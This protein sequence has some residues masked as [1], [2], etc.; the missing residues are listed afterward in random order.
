MSQQSNT[1]KAL[2]S[3]SDTQELG[4]DLAKSVFNDEDVQEELYL[5]Y[6]SELVAWDI[7]ALQ[8]HKVWR[9]VKSYLQIMEIINDDGNRIENFGQALARSIYG[10]SSLR[11][12]PV[13]TVHNLTGKRP[14]GT[15]S[16]GLDSDE[17]DK[18]F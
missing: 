16:Y 7:T 3:K 12:T 14:L 11:Y 9:R 5:W 15:I 17:E 2:M 1:L 13:Y 8:T 4:F 6:W 10:G 18:P